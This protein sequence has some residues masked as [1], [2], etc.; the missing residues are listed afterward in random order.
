MSSPIII[1]TWV[2]LEG[3]KL[4]LIEDEGEIVAF[5]YG[6]LYEI[7]GMLAKPIAILDALYVEEA[8]AGRAA[9]HS[10]F[11]HS[12]PLPQKA[13]LAASSSRFYHAMKLPYVFTKS[14]LSKKRK[15]TWRW[16][17]G[18]TDSAVLLFIQMLAHHPRSCYTGSK[19]KSRLRF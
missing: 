5:L 18:S 12:K 3:H 1:S 7:P 13:G 17:Y 16:I 19:V 2:G 11:L 14:S 4:L 9:L 10:S 15:S 8:T 6:F